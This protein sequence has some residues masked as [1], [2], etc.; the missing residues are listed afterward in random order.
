MIK[1]LFNHTKKVLP[2]LAMLFWLPL[3][4]QIY[5]PDGLRM[6]GS[7]NDWTNEP[8]MD[9]DF[10]LQ[11]AAGGT[12]RWI[13]SFQHSGESGAQEFKFVSTS[14]SDPWGNQWAGNENVGI[15][16]ESD[17]IYG[18]PSDPNNSIQLQQNYWYTVV[19][20]DNGYENTTAI[21]METAAQPVTFTEVLQD[22]ILVTD[23]Q[24]VSV[25]ATLSAVPSASEKFF[26]RY[27][28]D[29]WETA[30]LLNLA[31]SGTQA[32]ATIPGQAS[33]T[34]VE[35]YVF[36][37]VIENPAADPDF[38]SLRFNNNGGVNFSYIVDQSFDCGGYESLVSSDPAFPLA[39]QSVTIFFNAAYGNGGLFDYEGDI[40]VHTGLITN[41]S[42]NSSDW[43][44]VK[45]DWGEN[46]PETKMERLEDNVYSLTIADMRSYYGIPAAETIEKLA[47]VFRSDVENADGNFLEQ[48]NADGS[49]IFVDVYPLSLQVKIISPNRKE[50]LVSP[51]SVLPV[52]V[53]AMQNTS[54]S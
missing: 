9:G 6:P 1:I 22:P 28:T 45:T 17:F 20:R 19:W 3:T 13:T 11:K 33:Q 49:D 36:S 37:T 54:I 26:L 52:C 51:N 44:Y 46:T 5:E 41:E 10:E 16:T 35:Y 29:D 4:A 50:P 21:F 15:N 48:K 7:W 2:L 31:L 40:Y 18:V 24:A 23:Q 30:S 38:Y 32:T 34:E 43:K 12:A 53:E 8:N 47:F 27:S 25:T 42:Q 39:N 14:F